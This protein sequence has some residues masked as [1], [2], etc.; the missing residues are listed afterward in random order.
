MRVLAAILRIELAG[1]PLPVEA[2]R[3]LGMVSDI[4]P[5][6]SD[7]RPTYTGWYFD[8]FIDREDA[9][10]RADFVADYATS[11][12]GVGYVGAQ[13]AV[14]AIV[15]VDTGGPPRALIGP[16]AR[17][18][19]HWGNGPR[20][21]DETA[22]KLPA[23]DRPAPWSAHYTAPAPPAPAFEAQIEP[24]EDHLYL[25]IK[26]PRALGALVVEVLD[27]HRL[28]IQRLTR[29]IGAGTTRFAF[30]PKLETT[31]ATVRFRIG[32]W[33][34]YSELHCMDGCWISPPE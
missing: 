11:T 19:E 30:D 9:I 14:L 6:G 32:R 28:P 29:R 12:S 25:A 13:P 18:Y 24:R 20:L 1:Q 22:A 34:G 8:L 17:A 26:A 33:S 15:A 3:F 31:R 2:Q 4:G 7:G 10:A 21:D 5:Y 23:T 16:V 27:H